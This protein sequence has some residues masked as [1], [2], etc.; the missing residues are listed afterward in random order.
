[1]L[2]VVC[3][4][5]ILQ[6]PWHPKE[7]A[8]KL[9]HLGDNSLM[10]LLM[11]SVW[12]MIIPNWVGPWR[13]MILS[14]TQQWHHKWELWVELG[15]LRYRLLVLPS[16]RS[17][18]MMRVMTILHSWLLQAQCLFQRMATRM[19]VMPHPLLSHQLLKHQILLIGRVSRAWRLYIM[20]V[21]NEKGKTRLHGWFM[22]SPD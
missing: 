2:V 9:R 6:V 12:V 19:K 14:L 20:R 4:L 21:Y 13:F 3:L 1:M 10:S 7:N 5:F 15:R 18:G 22:R 17:K 8:Y 16:L 11:M